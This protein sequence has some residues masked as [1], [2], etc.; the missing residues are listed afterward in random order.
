MPTPRS[1]MTLDMVR[2]KAQQ[3]IP[4]RPTAPP[5]CPGKQAFPSH[6]QHGLMFI[7]AF[8]LAW[9]SSHTLIL[10][11]WTLIPILYTILSVPPYPL[12]SPPIPTLLLWV[13]LFRDIG[14][15][16]LCI[17][18]RLIRLLS[19]TSHHQL[20][21]LMSLARVSRRWLGV[22]LS[23]TPGFGPSRASPN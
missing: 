1:C 7:Y 16:L 21:V 15:D 14:V 11:S 23:Q 13:L 8:V 3:T 18:R 2:L 5:L 20:G 4:I 9:R 6:R 17:L 22:F 10:V 12:P 19:Y